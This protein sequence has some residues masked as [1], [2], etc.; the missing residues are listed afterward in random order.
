M[1]TFALDI[2]S[3]TRSCG[4]GREPWRVDPLTRK[5]FVHSVIALL[6]PGEAERFRSAFVYESGHLDNRGLSADGQAIYSLL[7]ALDEDQAETA[8]HRLPQAI[9]E[10]LAA[11][12]P[13]DYLKD[14]HAPLIVLL[15]DR[16]DQVVPVGESRRLCS[17]LAGHAGV[18]YTEMMFQH[19]DPL[20]GKLPLLRLA[21]ELG[22]FFLAVYPLFRQ[23]VAS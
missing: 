4:D 15:H 18:H 1:W 5:V 23:A 14:I 20:K 7:T 16:G 6:E 19:L 13:L 2:A 17:A 10:R 22:K 11:L 12:S 3:A 21:R 9:Q 8:L